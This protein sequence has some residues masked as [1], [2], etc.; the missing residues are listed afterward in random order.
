M[1]LVDTPPPLIYRYRYLTH[2]QYFIN[3]LQNKEK[4]PVLNSLLSF[5]APPWRCD[6]ALCCIA[7]SHDSTQWCIAQSCDSV[8]WC[9]ARSQQENF[10]LEFHTELHSA[11]LQRNLLFKNSVLCISRNSAPCCRAQRPDSALWCIA[12][13]FIAQRGVE[14]PMLQLLLQ[15]LRQQYSKKWP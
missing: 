11:E 6:S 10:W 2:L 12:Q 4:H 7:Q 15:T 13:S 1:V 5:R 8:Q 3:F 14:T 9:I